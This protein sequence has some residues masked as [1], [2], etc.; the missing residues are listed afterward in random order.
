MKALK[1]L[2]EYTYTLDIVKNTG[3]IVATF[4]ANIKNT[5]GI[6]T[7]IMDYEATNQNID[8]IKNEYKI[9]IEEAKQK[10][11]DNNVLVF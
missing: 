2:L 1:S 10:A 7:C 11:L 3:E 8:F 6:S 4:T 9:F 5:W